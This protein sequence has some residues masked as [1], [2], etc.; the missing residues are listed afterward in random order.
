MQKRWDSPESRHNRSMDC[1]AIAARL[2]ELLAAQAEPKGIA[3]AY[4][5]GSAARG[6]ARPGS[7]V[8]VGVLYSQDPPRTLAGMGFDLEGEMEKLLRLPVQVVVL[9]RAPADL[10]FRVLRDDKLLVERDRSARVRFEVRSRNEYW[11]LEPL[12]RSYR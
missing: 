8:D 12:L 10:V 5:F 1:Q 6:T 3:A 2:R 7:D 11:D 4:L 9:N